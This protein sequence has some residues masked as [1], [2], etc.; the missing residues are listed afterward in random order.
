MRY[1]EIVI[2]PA[3]SGFGEYEARAINLDEGYESD[4][5]RGR[6]QNEPARVFALVTEDCVSYVGIVGL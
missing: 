3:D 4:D 1:H 2:K 5:I 6:I